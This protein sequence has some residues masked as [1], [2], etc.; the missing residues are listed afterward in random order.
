M[1]DA[2][3]IFD[4][5]TRSASDLRKEGPYK[6]SLHPTTRLTCLALKIVGE[7]K[8]YFL[9]FHVIGR[10]WKDQNP[11]FKK[12]WQRL[13]D[14]GYLFG[15]HN[16]GF[17]FALYTN[18]LIKR[19]GW[20]EI[21]V[22]QYRCT[23][24]KAAA[25]ALPRSLEGVGEA[26]RLTTQKDRT[27][28]LAMLATCKPT[29][30]Y[31]AWVQTDADLKAG[32][33][34]GPKRMNAHTAQP[35]PMFLEPDAAPEVFQTLY[36]Y[37]KIDVLT[38]ELVDKTLPDLLP[39]EQKIWQFNQ[40]LNWRG[41]RFDRP[42]V[43]K[44]VGILARENEKGKEEIDDLTMGFV[45]SPGCLKSILEF[46]ETEDVELP[47]LKAKTVED[48]LKNFFLSDRARNLLEL[49]QALSKASTKKFNKFLDRGTGDRVRDILLYHGAST[50]RD[51]GTGIQPHNFPRG[52]IKNPANNPYQAT[53]DVA[54]WP[55]EALKFFY[56]EGSLGILFSSILRNMI[57]PDEGYEMYVAD[58]SK[59]E[60]AVLWW[61]AENKYG[62]EILRSGRDPYKV[63]A[64]D[65]LSCKYEEIK[66]DS[67]DRQLGKAQILGAGFGMGAPKFQSTAWD[68]YRL[69][70][71]L[72]QAK[73]AIQSYRRVHHAV[74]ALWKAYEVAAV[75][76]VVNPGEMVNAGKCSF[77]LKNGFLW[78]TLPSG[79][80][81][82]YREPQLSWQETEWGPRRSLEFWGLDK[83]KKKLQLE[84]TWGGTLT[85]NIVQAVARDLMMPAMLRLENRGYQGILMV[86]DEGLTQ[87]KIGEGSVEEFVEI[88]CEIPPWGEGLPI[89]A[90]G[91]CG[92][93]YRK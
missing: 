42:V 82:T 23:A 2:R 74:P 58:F 46:L 30:K 85:E 67:D 9:P 88:M 24:A 31:K 66:D 76:A 5:E 64:A 38:E 10:H 79:R 11:D 72:E 7:P 19:Q 62:L 34:V 22:Y 55:A 16:A 75:C 69:K 25:V 59:I 57:I 52:L 14:A 47:N 87:K 81:L 27:G 68:M 28:Y 48:A 61:L 63:Q 51:T 50:G 80:S 37:C 54:Q 90:K 78:A 21:P 20:P 8:M 33:K 12:L 32:K 26:L 1:I 70:L 45:E 6:Y 60:V 43:E 15:A 44:V 4:M 13:I 40:K 84:R 89:E 71:S 29:R 77:F 41:L 49:R 83:S 3:L 92:P 65:N 91:W 53:E 35:P 36:Q 93:R 86:H 39:Q 73:L 56:G 18:V 17:E